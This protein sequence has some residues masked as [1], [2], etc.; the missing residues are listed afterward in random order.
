MSRR[1]VCVVGSGTSYLSGISYYTYFLSRALAADS[2]VS[3]I[4]M[5]K[6]VP[7]ALYPGGARVG[8]A[9]TKVSTAEFAPTFDGV[10]WTLLPSLPRA[11]GFLRRRRPQ[12]LL[13]QWWSVSSLPA[14]L[15]FVGAARRIGA[16][17]IVE[18]HED[19]DTAEARLPLVGRLATRWL[20]LILDRC[21]A[22][23]VHSDWDRQRFHDRYQLDDAR[24]HVIP[25]GPFDLVDV[26]AATPD[27]APAAE[28]TITILFF[29]TIRPYKG[30]EDLVDAFDGL[31]RDA[32]ATWRLVVV[33]ETWEGWTLPFE[34]IAASPHRSDI[35]V[36][37][38]YVSDEE[39]STF[40]AAADLVAL[41]YLRSSASGPLH[42][43]MTAGLPV[44][45]TRVGGLESAAGAYSG[46]VFVNAAEPDDLRRGILEA[47]R[48]TG[49]RYEDPYSWDTIAERY[50]AVFAG[51][52]LRPR[53]RRRGIAEVR[54]DR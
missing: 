7:K 22:Y 50:E 14:Y 30:L 10:D 35:E 19:V 31:P 45:V 53:T 1:R 11:V 51:L 5:R 24:I 40:F 20:R 23:V 12:V 29:G 46:A 9:F 44:V 25:H 49:R 17:V 18:L 8:G 2:D 34:K 47:S 33:G 27:S 37:N 38:R 4:L 43:T 39:A 16:G 26:P 6:L 3:V 41:P 42:L 15:R 52:A 54:G 36:V 32:G 21:D 13:L 48:L 28:G